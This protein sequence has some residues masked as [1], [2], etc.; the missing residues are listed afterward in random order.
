MRAAAT[1]RRTSNRDFLLPTS[2]TKP[3]ELLINALI[4][5]SSLLFYLC[6]QPLELRINALIE[7]SSLLSYLCNQPLELLINALIEISSLLFYLCNQTSGI[8]QQCID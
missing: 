1:T 7:I 5:I 3:L 8:T 4:E 2:A 6:N